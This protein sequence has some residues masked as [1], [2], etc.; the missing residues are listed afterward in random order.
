VSDAAPKPRVFR[1]PALA[2]LAVLFLFFGAM[3]I[4][5][6]QHGAETE[7]AVVGPQ[8]TVLIVPLLAAVFIARWATFVDPDGLTVRAAFGRQR[9]TWD[10]V[11]GLALD[12]TRVYAVL[13]DGSVRLPCV[14]VA[15]L[16]AVSRASAGHLPE[17]ADPRPKFAP[18]RR[19]R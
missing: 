5:F 8:T 12:G 3:P 2:Y 1:L 17:L 4:A 19:R 9:Y 16:G 13:T 14:R 7:S 6:T 15:D 11:R 18:Q 10:E